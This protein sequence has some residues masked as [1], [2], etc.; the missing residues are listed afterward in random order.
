[1]NRLVPLPV[2]VPVP[3]VLVPVPVPVVAVLEYGVTR[4]RVLE[5][6]STIIVQ[7]LL[8]RSYCQPV[9]FVAIDKLIMRV[10]MIINTRVLGGS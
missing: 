6:S 4:T 2:A 1:M 9:T 3:V 10:H 8:P 5:Y 7:L